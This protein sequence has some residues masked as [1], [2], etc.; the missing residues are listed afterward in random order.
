V[1]GGVSA[2]SRLRADL[3]AFCDARGVALRLARMEHC[4][5]NA[6]M[7]AGLGARLL[8]AGQTADLSLAPVPTTAC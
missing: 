1:G 3:A 5:D 7:I 4:I 6:A 2:N 8:D